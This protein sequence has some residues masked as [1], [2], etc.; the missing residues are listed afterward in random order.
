MW[1]AIDA[2]CERVPRQRAERDRP[3]EDGNRRQVVFDGFREHLRAHGYTPQW[4][5]GICGIKA[6][7]ITRLAREF[8]GTKPH[9]DLDGG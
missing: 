3:G 2:V 5:E 1:W 9:A 7:T 6:E 4:A 8:A